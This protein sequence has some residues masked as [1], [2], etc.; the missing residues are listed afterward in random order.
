M[1][2]V[3]E[4][5]AKFLRW[6]DHWDQVQQQDQGGVQQAMFG[7]PYTRFDDMDMTSTVIDGQYFALTLA[8]FREVRVTIEAVEGDAG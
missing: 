7:D 1:S 5:V 2:I 3:S 6:L 4:G 8:D